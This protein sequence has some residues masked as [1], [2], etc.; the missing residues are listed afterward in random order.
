M[1][2]RAIYAIVVTVVLYIVLTLALHLAI[3]YWAEIL[4]TLLALV[5]VFVGDTANLNR[6][7]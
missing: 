6:F 2:H 5:Y 3:P 4:Y 1:F 7:K